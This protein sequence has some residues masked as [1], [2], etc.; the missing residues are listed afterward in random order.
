MLEI[1]S[2]KIFFIG[3][4]QVQ[5]GQNHAN[6]L[7][8]SHQRRAGLPSSL[9][10]LRNFGVLIFMLAFLLLGSVAWGQADQI[11]PY[12]EGISHVLV[13]EASYSNNSS[14]AKADTNS[15]MDPLVA[16]DTKN[17]FSGRISNIIVSNKTHIKDESLNF[18]VSFTISPVVD[19]TNGTPYLEITVG[20]TTKQAPL[21]ANLGAFLQFAYTIADGDS[22]TDGVEINRVVLNGSTIRDNNGLDFDLTLPANTNS[23]LT[24][25]LV[26]GI[27]P[28]VTSVTVPA[29]NTYIAGN[30]L[31]FAVNY[32]EPVS[33]TGA[34][35]VSLIIGSTTRQAI[36]QTGSNNTNALLFRYTVQS[37]DE[38]TDGIAVGTLTTDGATLLDGPGNSAG[39]VLTNIGSTGNVKVDA[40]SPEVNSVTVPVDGTYTTGQDLD[41]TV[42]FDEAVTVTG[43]PQLALAVGSA[44]KQAVY[45]SGS[46]STA[47][48][49]RYTV[50]SGDEDTDGIAVGTLAANGG[51]LQ[52]GVLQDANLTLNNVGT[53]TNI[54]VDAVVPTVTSLAVPADG[55]YTTGQ[56]LDFTVNFDEAVTV[57]GSPQLSLTVGSATKQAVYQSG[58]GST[59]LLFRYTA[60][61]GDEDT[62]GIALGTLATN[63]GTLQ[64]GAGNGANLALNSAG[65]TTNINVDAKDPEV[66][67]VTVPADGT[68][69][70]GSHLDFTV[71]F[72]EVVTV[73]GTPQLALTVGSATKQAVYQS[74]SGSAALLFRYT[75]QSGDEDTDGIAVGTLA[76]NGGTLQDGL[77]NDANLS[78][79][80]IGATTNIKVNHLSPIFH[81]S[82]VPTDGTY[83]LGQVLNFSVAFDKGITANTT[84][85][86]PYL[87]VDI[88]GNIR[89]VNL[90]SEVA[91]FLVFQYHVQTNDLDVDG[92]RLLRLVLNG[93]IL[94]DGAGN[95][96]DISGVV[97]TDYPNI[98]VDGVV[99]AV[100]SVSVPSDGTYTAGQDLDFTVNFDDLVTV[101]G[102]PQLS[103]TVGS[104]TKQGI[105]QSGSGS[106]ALLFRY[107]VQSGD[108]DTDGIAVGALAANG[109]TL[110]D[111]AGND[112]SLS[113][114]NIGATT[115]I[116]VDAKGPEV[117]SV[118]VPADGTYTTGQ[119][120][121][122]IVNFD[123]V[124][125]LTGTAPQ[126]LLLVNNSTVQWNANYLS[127]SGTQAL[128]FRYTVQAGDEEAGGIGV[129]ILTNT[130][131]L[132]DG[133]GNTAIRTLNSVGSTANVIV[134][135]K[136]PELDAQASSPTD[137]ATNVTLSQ[138]LS[139]T[140]DD[141]M[142]VGTGNITIVETGVGNFE[143]LDVTNGS[144]VTISN[145]VVT[146]NPSG[147]LKKA[148]AYHL[149]IDATALDDDASNSFAG[150]TDLTILNFSTVDVVI[151]EIVTDPQQDWSS[152]NFASTPSSGS[153]GTD[154][155]WVE[156]FIKSPGI[157]LTGW[158]IELLDGSDVIGDLSNT[159]AF[160]VS[161]YTSSGSGTFTNTAVGDYLVLGNVASSGALN[162]TGLTI[163]LKDP[164][165]AIVDVATVGVANPP[166]FPGSSQSGN[167]NG[168]SA[169]SVQRFA[170]GSDTNIDLVDFT[171]GPASIAAANTGPSVT[172]SIDNSQISE[173]GTATITATRSANSAQ[174][175]TVTI[176]VK[177]GSEA[178]EVTDFTLSAKTI[179][180]PNG[181]TTGTV[182][183]TAVQDALFE[184]D[185][186]TTIEITGVTNGTEAGNQETSLLILNSD[187]Q[188]VIAFSS[189]SSSGDESTSSANLEVTL[190]AVS[191][192]DA[193]VS[194]TVTGTA[195]NIDY[196]LADG[197]LTI[198]A[199]STSQNITIA[200]IVD[201]ALD[202]VDETVIVTLSGPGNATLGT[203]TV[204][205]Y[206][207]TDND[208]EPTVSLTVDNG[209]IVE[210]AGTA[211]LTA[212]L[213]AVSSKDVT[214][215]LG[216]TGTATLGTDYNN[217]VATSIVI[218]AGNLSASASPIITA[219]QDN[220]PESN[221]TIIVDVTGVTNGS[222]NGSQQQTVTIIDDDAVQFS[223]DD[224]TVTEGNAG[225]TTL[226]YTVS[227]NNAASGTVT[228]DYATSD[229]T[230]TAGSDY[231]ALNTTTLTFAAG[232]TSKT[233]DV[234]VIGDQTLEGNETIN[235]DLSNATGLSVIADAQGVGTITNDDAAAVT[236]A[237]ISGAEN[238]GAITVT[239]TLDNA[240]QGG[241][242]V[243]VS[244]ADGTATTADSDYTTITSQTLTFA[245][246]AGETQTFTVTPTADT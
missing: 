241:F 1:R 134:D 7:F 44:T 94:Q 198:P 139:L 100:T 11:T 233:V 123:E 136:A 102:T 217:T 59:A 10:A 8:H 194:Y 221:E 21:F 111:G 220:T 81:N 28:N 202:E 60:Q 215:N 93:G 235:L 182:T 167:S 210:A 201:D 14:I 193:T 49:F 92:I 16:N 170:N 160:D 230:A 208:P 58:S 236:I 89:Q 5:E 34:P 114:N 126:L 169:E 140:F 84:N 153:S 196:T 121:D 66:S 41:F 2:G 180:I 172:L 12:N 67:S 38:D 219:T 55:T 52:D 115:N 61:S 15:E 3:L 129:L 116:N 118:T 192:V 238:G 224:P 232:E 141:N 72:D 204:H 137:G 178:L 62:D 163:N 144:L 31:D 142:V 147:T 45:Q 108:E 107:T 228:V 82:Q 96:A 18:L 75:V 199:G 91:G 237:D 185:E 22:D 179:T 213:S 175:T 161:N 13:S 51:T 203:N 86:I 146:L 40:K 124:L 206:T 218:T 46:G 207:I 56:N 36:F 4:G 25:V 186:N 127:G 98:K 164:G 117:V 176:D 83:T 191:G 197:T 68:Y 69:G 39:L 205:T 156:L 112:A 145:N 95:D 32:T 155:E 106:T 173:T 128:T 48:L 138:N 105:Y 70:I 234:S 17:E 157:D 64:D 177:S 171:F 109:G 65:A 226:T 23:L 99:P 33:V 85:G 130:G 43:T 150:V 120:L 222:E 131:T 42:N 187:A 57:T 122:F 37:G 223:V 168:V 76:A 143:Q 19:M 184:L 133:V 26:D 20:S 71:N 183:L 50:Q 74:G 132:Q 159:G 174:T 135:A 24:A 243:D 88:G 29:D 214:V 97:A 54:N 125:T 165:G 227:L 166:P 246:T 245:G 101:T 79:N 63:G 149:L 231:T 154:D 30:D 229:G 158:T 35:Q 6:L 211:T 77:L 244:T 148:T 53:T 225:T 90:F 239:A 209:S 73:T 188:P 119:H 240:V 212:T 195:T 200:S 87:E 242:T 151:N 9:F 104:A 113:L 47:L 162:N 152:T 190:S 103:L 27:V 181:A 80:N 110:Q 78:L 216:Y 189:T